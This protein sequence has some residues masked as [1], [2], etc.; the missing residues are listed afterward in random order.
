MSTTRYDNCHSILYKWEISIIKGFKQ[1]LENGM[2]S[3]PYY[4]N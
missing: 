4:K 2:S 3:F 1:D